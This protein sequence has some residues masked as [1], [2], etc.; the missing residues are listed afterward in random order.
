[1]KPE[2]NGD[3]SFT[4]WEG[5]KGRREEEREGGKE[6]GKREGGEEERRKVGWSLCVLCYYEAFFPCRP[7][8][9]VS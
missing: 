7:K 1:M 2:G 3:P 6:E 9:F 8:Q 4:T 5:R